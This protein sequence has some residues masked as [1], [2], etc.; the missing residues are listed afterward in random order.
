MFCLVYRSLYPSYHIEKSQ[1]KEALSTLDMSESI[2]ADA[3]GTEDLTEYELRICRG[4][5][6]AAFVM[7]DQDTYF[8]YA[9][10]E[11]NIETARSKEPSTR[12]ATANIHMGIAYNFNSLW[13]EAEKYLNES[14]RI[15]EAM[16]GF[17]KDWLF[18]PLYQL[19]HTLYHRGKY[20]EA[21]EVLEAAINDRV[22]AFKEADSYSVR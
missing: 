2:L 13:K 16:P 19:A 6:G 20:T 17:R 9:E 14:K 11:Y 8:D 15:R 7:R 5:I 22:E 4:R 10:K 12:L 3:R 21:A 1:A 18:S